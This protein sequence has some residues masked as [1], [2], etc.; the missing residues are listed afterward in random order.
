MTPSLDQSNHVKT[1]RILVVGAGFAGATV[2]RTLAEAGY[3]VLVIDARNH[4]AGNAY[5]YINEHNTRVHKYGPHLWHT[6]ND[7]VQSWASRFTD[8]LPYKHHVKAQLSDGRCV[9]LPIN[10]K[11]I[12]MVFGQ[13]F[14]D[15]C[16][17]NGWDAPY[18]EIHSGAH[19]AFLDSLTVKHE[20]VTN[21]LEHVESSVGRELCNLFF[22]PYTKKMWGLDLKQ[23][24]AS[25]AARIPTNV[26][27][28]SDLY[29]PK[30]K[31]QYLPKEG[32]T[33]MVSNILNHPNI[34]VQLGISRQELLRSENRQSWESALGF[35]L[36]FSHTFTSEPIDTY[37]DCHLG[38]LPWRSIKMHTYSVPV[39]NALE[40][41]VVNFTH[42]GEFTRITEWK[43]LPGHGDNS[44][45]TTLTAEQP[46][47]YRDNNNE[48]Y[49][50]V[51][52]SQTDC[53]HRAL[54]QKYRELAD[55]DS[56]VTFIGR[57]GMYVYT[58]MAPCISSSLAIANK[59]LKEQNEV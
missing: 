40:A 54:Y 23:L 44:V 32:Y 26:E 1:N 10:Q 45:W 39:I 31:H 2:A 17:E 7:E 6:S 36:Q 12:E 4:V 5:D 53:P 46:C 13:R 19:A 59:W 8:W 48:R 15:W 14:F 3:Q 16:H 55:Q 22:G 20:N 28:N 35:K 33:V 57:C 21:S 47:D 38:E 56:T 58:D 49:Y 41:P 37:F 9:P 27:T 29:F 43:Q 50:P 42:S 34:K 51:K 18:G 24:P 52:T 30:D 25:V 11:T